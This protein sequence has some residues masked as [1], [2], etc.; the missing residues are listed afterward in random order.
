MKKEISVKKANW[1]GI[2]TM[3]LVAAACITVAELCTS[4]A[5][6][7]VYVDSSTGQ[8]VISLDAKTID[9]KTVFVDGKISFLKLV[10]IT[11]DG[12]THQYLYWAGMDSDVVEH[13]AGCKYC[14][15]HQEDL[16]SPD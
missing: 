13:W 11:A 6:E 7:T 8:R 2:L 10:D 15:E 9:A 3:L 16:I 12:E 5:P 14:K 1:I 4:C